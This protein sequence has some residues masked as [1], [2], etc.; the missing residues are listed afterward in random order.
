M[1][2]PVDAPRLVLRSLRDAR[3]NS[4]RRF[5]DRSVRVQKDDG[6]APEIDN[7][8]LEPAE[9]EVG[10]VA[11]VNA[12][13]D[14]TDPDGDLESVEVTLTVGGQDQTLETQLMGAS[15]VKQGPA[16]IIMQLMA[17]AEGDV[18]VG[19]V[20][21]DEQCNPS[22]RLDGSLDA[23]VN[24]DGGDDCDTT[25]SGT[26]GEMCSQDAELLDAFTLR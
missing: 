3:P 24:N 23:F 18:G 14:F 17:Q 16:Q 8:R 7:L 25:G 11:T 22:D 9:I 26:T 10:V 1:P 20:A 21:I 13:F 5:A 19:L 4:S 15:G 2:V 12:F 6:E